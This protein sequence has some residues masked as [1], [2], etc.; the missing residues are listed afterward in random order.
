M[1]VP[2]EGF[3]DGADVAFATPTPSTAMHKVPTKTPTPSVEPVPREEGT[4]TERVGKTT[5]LLAETPTPPERAI[6]PAAVQ[7]KTA[8]SVLPLIIS[9]SDPFAV[10][11]QAVKDGASLVVILS[12]IPSSPTRGP[13]TD[14]SSEGSDDILEDPD[15]API[16]KKKISDSDKEE[17]A[18]PEP[19]FMGMGMCLFFFFANFT[20]P[21]LFFICTCVSSVRLLPCLQRLWRGQESQQA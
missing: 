20:P 15:N 2:M 21:P 8:P 18:S 1:G 14:L 10:I 7:T 4:H 5:P 16:L 3:F 19:D 12:S 17:S 9:T 6:S 11:S 13:D